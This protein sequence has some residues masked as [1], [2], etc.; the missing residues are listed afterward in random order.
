[1]KNKSSRKLRTLGL[2]VIAVALALFALSQSCTKT[3]TPS[4]LKIGALL[5]MTGPAASTGDQL[6]KAINLAVQDHTSRT[7]NKADIIL[8]DS[9][10][11]PG[12]GV[13]AFRKL[14]T[15]DHV[16]FVI[17]SLS[18]VSQ[19]VAPIANSEKMPAFALASAPIS[20]S[21]NDYMLRWFIDGAGE[22][23][24]M[25]DYLVSKGY[26]RVAVMNINDNYGRVLLDEFKAQLKTKGIEPV[27]VEGFDPKN[28]D[29]RSLAF[30]AKEANPDAVYFIAYGRP[31]GIA[32]R[33]TSEAGLKAPF[34]T[35][36]GFEIAGTRELAGN[37]AEGL[38]YTSI[39]YGEGVTT[40]AAT[41]SFVSRFREVYKMEPSSD[42]A[43]AY[44]LTSKLL[45][46]NLPKGS[47]REWVSQKF[48]TQF[49]ELT[50]SP[51]LEVLA[52]V[53]LKRIENSR[54]SPITLSN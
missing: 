28:D 8:E 31:L 18:G 17:V 2:V 39:A 11:D 9:K 24:M 12:T 21:P 14:A 42:A 27:S 19:A 52:P 1:M 29:F 37:A 16:N 3:P 41:Q 36:F 30:R 13:N 25:A 40:S 45:S 47:P 33:Q 5:P 46:G 34:V 53:I 35:T 10:N 32:L 50:V 6:N 26:R 54:V 4:S 7:G 44:D 22:A 15:V 49:G 51:S 23:R 48:Q 20:A 43:L 38:V